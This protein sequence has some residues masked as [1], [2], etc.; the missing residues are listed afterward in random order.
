M[1]KINKLLLL[2][3]LITLPF[4]LYGEEVKEKEVKVKKEK[5]LLSYEKDPFV[6]INKK[7]YVFNYYADNLVILPMVDIYTT[8]VPPTMRKGVYNVINNLR[9]P[10]NAFNNL[11]LL[12]PMG[13]GRTI[14]RFCINTI[15]GI[16]GLFNPA[17]SI[18]LP[19]E[20]KTINDVLI[21]YKVKSG[22][23]LIVP[24]LGPSDFRRLGSQVTE[25]IL[26]QDLSIPNY[27]INGINWK[28]MYYTILGVDYRDRIKFKYFITGSPLEYD[29]IRGV[30]FKL[31]EAKA[32]KAEKERKE[33]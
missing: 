14:A 15:A 11:L 24:I 18:G 31:N 8:L 12:D 13:F 29:F 6:K 7:I 4:T 30:Y 10:V 27:Y 19:Y 5:L 33:D 9:E 22:P 25:L 3:I 32:K 20:K 28:M 1:R 23:Y 16:F 17:A 26:T 2:I 21:Y